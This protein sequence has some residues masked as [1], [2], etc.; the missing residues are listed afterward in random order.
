MGDLKSLMSMIPGVSK[1]MKDVDIDEKALVRVEAIIQS[2]TPA[3]RADPDSLNLSRKKRIAKGCGQTIEQIN[4][5]VKNFNDM[6]K[7]M[8]QMANSPMGKFGMP[9]MGGMPGVGMPKG[10]R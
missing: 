9:G 10:R 2:M 7:F 6:R 1:A 5:F 4:M 3:E 8:H